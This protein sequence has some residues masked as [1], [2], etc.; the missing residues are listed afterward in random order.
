[1]STVGISSSH[2]RIGFRFFMDSVLAGLEVIL[3]SITRRSIMNHNSNAKRN[4]KPLDASQD[5][6][7]NVE[8]K[9]VLPE[10]SP[11]QIR[12]NVGQ[13]R[14]DASLNQPK[15]PRD[16]NNA[17]A[18]RDRAVPPYAH[19]TVAARST[20]ASTTACSQSPPLVPALTGDS[21]HLNADANTNTPTHT[22]VTGAAYRRRFKRL[23]AEG[24]A[25]LAPTTVSINLFAE[26]LIDKKRP[27]L[28]AGITFFVTSFFGVNM[29][30]EQQRYDVIERIGSNIEIRQYPTRIVAETTVDATKSDNPRG[31]GFRTVAAYIFGANKAR[32]KID[33]TAPVEVNTANNI[34]V[35][36]FFMPSN[37]S[38]SDLP[39]PS[40]PR[41]KLIELKPMTAAVLRF[42]G[43][44][45]GEKASA[46]TAELTTAIGN[47]SWRVTGALPHFSIIRLGHCRFCGGT[48][49]W[50]LSQNKIVASINS[51]AIQRNDPRGGT[52]LRSVLAGHRVGG[53]KMRPVC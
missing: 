7:C 49:W 47:T 16:S 33:M 21:P 20:S 1:M 31:D 19:L 6:S 10:G 27:G 52:P 43:S 29:S 45:A 15:P 24:I 40:D 46:R 41:V 48:K 17:S 22:T 53:R 50:F 13:A 4:T 23:G 38:R 3:A 9:R 28:A 36:R 18:H 35:M 26:W 32:Q 11:D 42:S 51:L 44:T 12:S 37:Y 14:L 30:T 8:S 5:V 34:L 2:A 25:A 39:D